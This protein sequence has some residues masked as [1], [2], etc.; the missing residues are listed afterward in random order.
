MATIEDVAAKAKVSTATVSRTLAKPSLVKPETRTRVLAA[1]AALDYHPNAAAKVLRTTRTAK[2]LVT[3]PDIS[4]PFFSSVIRGV[5]EAAQEAGY[6]VL[7]GD[8]RHDPDRDEQYALMLGR[9]EAD[10][11]I[12]LGHILPPTASRIV[13]AMGGR[14]PVVNGCEYSPELGV[15]SV[16]IDNRAAAREAMAHLYGLDHSRIAVI[17]GPLDS[18]LSRD[19]LDGVKLAAT[20][21]GQD[22]SLIVRTGDFS[23]ESGEAEAARLLSEAPR[24][25]AMFCFSD[26]TAI[27]ALKAIREAGLVCPRDVSVVG[28]DDVKLSKFIDPPLTTVRQPMMALG[29]ETVRLMLDILAG[30]N[31][32]IASLTLGHELVVRA[33]TAP[34]ASAGANRIVRTA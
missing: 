21:A 3:V 5:E 25:T 29:R 14:A 9:K 26:D 23:I 1:I 34:R 32:G 16:H 27:G 13:A 33:S 4:N 18:P 17:T 15:S 30:R 22:E 12:F 8:T 6:A 2:L 31:S 11:L 28:F 20:A 10:G 24:P 19:R 7:L